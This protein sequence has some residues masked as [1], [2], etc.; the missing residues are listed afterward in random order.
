ML[1]RSG[2]V[3]TSRAL[4]AEPSARRLGLVQ[5]RALEHTVD[6]PGG[7]NGQCRA[8]AVDQCTE[9]IMSIPSRRSSC[10]EKRGVHCDHERLLR[11]SHDRFHALMSTVRHG[12][13]CGELAH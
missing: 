12:Q 4:C 6:R 7:Y 11:L 2:R 10:F 8:T 1:C 13:F 9:A 5:R 3:R